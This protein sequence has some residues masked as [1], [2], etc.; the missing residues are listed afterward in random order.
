[1][2]IHELMHTSES[3]VKAINMGFDTARIKRISMEDGMHTLHQDRMQKVRAGVSTIE[4]AIAT[5]PSDV[6]EILSLR[7]DMKSYS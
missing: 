6:E 4:E 2:G 7:E 1:M 3:L 5:V